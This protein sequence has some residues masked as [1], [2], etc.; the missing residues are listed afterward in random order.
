MF[1]YSL[2][3]VEYSL[4]ARLSSKA[5]KFCRKMA[6]ATLRCCVYKTSAVCG[7]WWAEAEACFSAAAI[8]FSSPLFI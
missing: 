6:V 4:I 1:L 7:S 5:K 2:L 8:Q 3:I